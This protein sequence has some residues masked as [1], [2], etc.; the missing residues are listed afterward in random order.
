MDGN[1]ASENGNS[2]RMIRF[3]LANPESDQTTD[4]RS[5]HAQGGAHAPERVQ[6]LQAAEAG[7]PAGGPRGCAGAI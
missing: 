7:C 2:L 5:G 1:D 4:K 3:A 6:M